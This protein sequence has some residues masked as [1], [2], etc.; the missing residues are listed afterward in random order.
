MAQSY[1]LYLGNLFQVGEQHRGAIGALV[2]A[3]Y[4]STFERVLGEYTTEDGTRNKST[5]TFGQRPYIAE[6]GFYAMFEGEFGSAN[7]QKATSDRTQLYLTI[8]LDGFAREIRGEPV[9]NDNVATG[10]TLQSGL[11][12]KLVWKASPTHWFALS[13]GWMYASKDAGKTTQRVGPLYN[14]AQDRREMHLTDWQGDVALYADRSGPQIVQLST[15]GALTVI[16]TH[17]KAFNGLPFKFAPA[18]Y[19]G[20]KTVVAGDTLLGF[21]DDGTWKKLEVIAVDGFLNVTTDPDGNLWA[22]SQNGVQ[23]PSDFHVYRYAP[24]QTKPTVIDFELGALPVRAFHSVH[25]LPDGTMRFIA[26]SRYARDYRGYSICEAGPAV[27]ESHIERVVIEPLEA[28]LG[29]RVGSAERG[30]HRYGADDSRQ[31]PRDV[32]HDEPE[33]GADRC[34]RWVDSVSH[35]VGRHADGVADEE[36]PT[37]LDALVRGEA[38]PQSPVS[39]RPRSGLYPL[40]HRLLARG[41]RQPRHSRLHRHRRRQAGGAEELDHSMVSFDWPETLTPGMHPVTL[42]NGEKGFSIE[43]MVELLPDTAPGVLLHDAPASNA[44]TYAHPRP[45]LTSQGLFATYTFWPEGSTANGEPVPGVPYPLLAKVGVP[46]YDFD[47]PWELLPPLAVT[48][49]GA[50]PAFPSHVMERGGTL[51]LFATDTDQTFVNRSLVYRL[52]PTTSG[53]AGWTTPIVGRIST[54]TMINEPSMLSAVGMSAGAPV[55]VLATGFGRRTLVAPLTFHADGG[56]QAGAMTDV[57]PAYGWQPMSGPPKTLGAWVV[58]AGVTAGTATEVRTAIDTRILAC[59]TEPD[60]FLWVERRAGAERLYSHRAGDAQ[61]QLMGVLPTGA[62]GVGQE[63]TYGANT[64]AAGVLDLARLP[65]GDVLLLV[66]EQRVAP[67][68]LRLIRWRAATGVF[69]VNARVTAPSTVLARGEVCIG[70]FTSKT[71]CEGWA[72]HGCAPFSCSVSPPELRARETT[73]IG[74]GNLTVRGA[75]VVV[76]YETVETNR[77]PST[78]YGGTDV[79]YLTV[80]LPP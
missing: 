71:G 36:W 9:S 41:R 2:T 13:N 58:D 49:Q 6:K 43:G 37:S 76:V 1:G 69:D 39:G 52:D 26:V 51:F 47:K 33:R 56:V 31:E 19:W 25:F 24:G 68:G 55:A 22:Y 48:G 57:G 32:E 45:V 70:P 34:L 53:F 17:K 46:A 60:G 73:L 74:E 29:E 54:P 42:V 27:T 77:V 64:N 5:L 3:D 30:L 38:A 62:P 8:V 67:R 50:R 7:A 66:S 15:S 78:S 18:G 44:L 14:S 12:A 80:P 75:E 79:L 16:N 20:T 35:L 59:N 11:K 40:R 65:G 72:R 63:Y 4:G 21:E 10:L 23:S 61:A 28:A